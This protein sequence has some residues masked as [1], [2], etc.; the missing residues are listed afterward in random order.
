[1]IRH[2]EGVVEKSGSTFTYEYFIKDHLGNT[3]LAFRPNGSSKTITQ[4]IVYY[5]FGHT[6]EIENSTSNQYKYNGKELQAELNWYDYGMRFYDP[7]GPRFLTI[8]PAAEKYYEISP[9]A[10]VANNPI[11]Y[12][13]PRGDTITVNNTGYIINNDEIDNVVYLQDGDRF[14]QIGELGGEIDVNE[15]YANLLEQNIEEAEGIINPFTF[16][17]HVKTNGKWDLKNDKK[18]IFGFGND[19]ETT[20]SFQGEEMESQDIGNHH[21][22]AVSLAYGLFPSEE[23][24]L[25][26]AGSYQIK[27]GTSR[28]EWQKYKTVQIPGSLRMGIPPSTRRIMLPPYG[29]DP[30]DQSWIKSGFNYYKSNK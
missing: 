7:V 21:F 28:P 13:D 14:V 1:M 22:G 19:G 2:P 15:I 27:S 20:F 5:P 26:Q 24:I 12:I 23:F 11:L 4:R 10:Y 17:K 3:R 29:D 8:D 30:R 6:A 16:K 18:S 9:Y 25:K